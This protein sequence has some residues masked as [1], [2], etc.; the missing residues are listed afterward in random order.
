[1]IDC[2]IKPDDIKIDDHSVWVATTDQS[3]NRQW[4]CYSTDEYAKQT[5]DRIQTSLDSISNVLSDTVVICG[6]QFGGSANSGATVKRLYAAAGKTAGVG[7]D[8]ETAVNDFDSIYPWCVRRRCC[9]YFD[10]AG[11]FVVNA[12]DGEPGYTTD[13]SNGEVWVEHSL[14][15]YRHT[16]DGGAETIVISSAAQ[17][18]FTPAPIFQRPDGTLR[19]KAYT[20]AYPMATVDGKATSRAGVFSDAYSLNSAMTAARTLGDGYT[21]TTT[22]EW[23][24]EC[25]YMWVEFA[26]RNLQSVMAGATNMPEG[27]TSTAVKAQ[28]AEM[29]V[30]RMIVDNASADQFV[31]GQTIRVTRGNTNIA[32]NRRITVITV[33]DESRKQLVFDGE[34][35]DISVGDAVRSSAWINGSCDGVLSSSGS[36]VSNT[37]GKH[38]CVYRGRETPYGN[39]FELMADLLFKREGAGTAD[40]PYTYDIY[41][42]PDPTK[43]A[44]GA[45]TDDYV[46]LNY[47]L[48]TAYGCAKKLGL[49]SRY[50]HVRLPAEVGASTTT[51]YSD[52]YY[53]PRSEVCM[54]R[55]GGMWSTGANA[56]P[57][58]WACNFG[59]TPVDVS[60]HA[61]LSHL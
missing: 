23:Y 27:D 46:R 18:G 52:Y 54:A 60:Y 30:N 3:G 7:T 19:Q 24:T 42:L 56:G 16:Y 10:S 59:T 38:N 8:T 50:P 20:A 37:D 9:G 47:A 13:G 28:V 14:F 53:Y 45:I 58:C 44:S 41:H 11:N 25:L 48:P 29:G 55:V 51:Y 31:L 57:S 21:V 15:Y 36:F 12:Y 32:A 61:R 49:D 22:A 1:M 33:Y 5:L 4:S 26:T 6:V 2:A 39:A 34:P 17:P 35:V 40:D 43:Y